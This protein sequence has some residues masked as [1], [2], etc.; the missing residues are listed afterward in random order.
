[1]SDSRPRSRSS[2]CLQWIGRW[3]EIA[4][5]SV[6]NLLGD[7]DGLDGFAYHLLLRRWRFWLLLWWCRWLRLMLDLQGGL[8]APAKQHFATPSKIDPFEHDEFGSLLRDAQPLYR[9]WP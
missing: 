2:P 4:R 9:H 6:V 1:M 8:L 3:S 5:Q 7:R